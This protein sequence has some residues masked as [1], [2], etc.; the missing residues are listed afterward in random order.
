[1]TMQYKSAGFD[2]KSAEKTGLIGGYANVYEIEDLGG[3]TVKMGAFADSIEG[4]SFPMLWGHDSGEM[5]I[6]I[7][8]KAFEDEHGLYIEGKLSLGMARAD[9]AFIGVK[10]GSI[11]GLSIGFKTIESK[12]T[13]SGREITKAELWETSLVTFPMNVESRIDAVKA[14]AA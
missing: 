1:M 11:S 5:P 2:L 7:W 6:G 12:D 13:K 3:D 4:K 14:S 9:D 10:A 8:T